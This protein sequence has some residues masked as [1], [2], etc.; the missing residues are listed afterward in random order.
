MHFLILASAQN[1]SVLEMKTKK[2][3]HGGLKHPF[4]QVEKNLDL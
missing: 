1:E 3:G 2:F 4:S